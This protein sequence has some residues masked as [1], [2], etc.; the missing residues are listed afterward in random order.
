MKSI[1]QLLGLT[2]MTGILL[3][4]TEAKQFE[5][6]FGRVM[7]AELVSHTGAEADLV[8][9]EKSGKKMDVKIDVFSEKDQQFIRDWMKKTPPTLA[10]AFRIQAVKKKLSEV[11]D[12]RSY[13]SSGKT[14]T[15]VFE[16]TVTN[17]TRQDVKDLR[18]DY[19]AVS[20][21]R[22]KKL[23]FQRGNETIKD[24]MR[25]NDSYT[26]ITAPAKVASSSGRSY[27]RWGS[28]YSYKESLLGV[29]L[30]IYGPDG[31]P[32]E[33]WKSPGTKMDQV[34]WDASEQSDTS[35]R[36]GFTGEDDDDDDGNRGRGDDRRGDDDRRQPDVRDLDALRK[37]LESG[38][39]PFR[40]DRG[41]NDAGGKV[42]DVKP[43]DFSKKFGSR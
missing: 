13:Y 18:I 24:P 36:R 11:K 4:A 23:K 2:A 28:S 29:I 5:D 17:L 14:T 6:K 21:D 35:R 37:L 39:N 26:F 27:S 12:R 40:K 38:E 10:Y 3:S 43:E 20:E 25:Y 19:R 7:V 8:K 9:I 22:S 15:Y 16:V 1:F 30:R 41:G 32:I 42:P 34:S 31:Q 33:Q